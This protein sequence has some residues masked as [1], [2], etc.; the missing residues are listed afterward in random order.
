MS[1]ERQVED[2]QGCALNTFKASGHHSPDN[3]V[4]LTGS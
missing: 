1:P 2:G 4:L 3:V